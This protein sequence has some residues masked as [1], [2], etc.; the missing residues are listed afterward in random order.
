[1][2]ILSALDFLTAHGIATVAVK[3]SFHFQQLIKLCHM[4]C[5]VTKIIVIMIQLIHL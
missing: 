5:Q 4:I 1:M 2:L 3:I